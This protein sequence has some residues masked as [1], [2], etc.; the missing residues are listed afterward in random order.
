MR[1]T[2]TENNRIITR[3]PLTATVT[4]LCSTV[5]APGPQPTGCVKGALNLKGRDRDKTQHTQNKVDLNPNL[6]TL[7]LC[8]TFETV[9]KCFR[10]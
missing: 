3:F 8:L 9:S 7:R 10:M 4:P 5:G 6:N 1:S 2:V